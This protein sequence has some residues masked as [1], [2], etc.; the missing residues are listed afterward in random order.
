MIHN[1]IFDNLNI[2]CKELFIRFVNI[3]KN[4]LNKV[5]DVIK[6]FIFLLNILV[7]FISLVYDIY[8]IFFTKERK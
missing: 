2:I 3:M 4:S 5:F 8:V 6:N 1:E 7:I